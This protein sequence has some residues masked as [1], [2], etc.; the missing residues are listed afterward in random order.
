MRPDPRE[1][2]ATAG[3]L[4][5][6]AA[7]ATAGGLLLAQTG[8][9]G[10]LVLGATVGAALV[11]LASAR[12]RPVPDWLLISVS[13]GVGW[14]VGALVT[15]ETVAAMGTA[16][17]PAVLAAALLMTAGIGVSLLLRVIGRAPPGDVLATSPGAME[18]LA[19]AAVERGTGP[20]EVA[21]FHTV[22]VLTVILSLPLLLALAS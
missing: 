5:G 22:R 7:G 18:A 11:T 15:P 17:V 3:Q 13:V 16:V 2:A 9:G 6:A 1:R 20:L 4:L 19:A 12:P 14:L 10:T 8:V 21:L